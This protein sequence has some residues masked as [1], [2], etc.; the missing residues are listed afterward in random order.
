MVRWTLVYAGC[1]SCLGRMPQLKMSYFPVISLLPVPV[2]ME[3]GPSWEEIIHKHKGLSGVEGS[4][5]WPP[6]QAL[7]Q[8]GLKAKDHI[9]H[10][11][12]TQYPALQVAWYLKFTPEVHSPVIPLP[13]KKILPWCRK[14]QGQLLVVMRSKQDQRC[15]VLNAKCTQTKGCSW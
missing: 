4:P 11:L 14:P 3:F 15:L 13:K 12:W 7:K 5:A 2:T 9:H 10:L 6:T 8:S 1:K